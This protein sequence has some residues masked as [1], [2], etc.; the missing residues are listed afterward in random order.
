MVTPETVPG[1][2]GASER[3]GSGR[4]RLMFLFARSGAVARGDSDMCWFLCVWI[5]SYS[6]EVAI[7]D[8]SVVGMVA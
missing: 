4:G 6:C 3:E 5:T 7:R 1:V 8:L 2:D